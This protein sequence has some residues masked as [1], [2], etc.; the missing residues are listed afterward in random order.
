MRS[1]YYKALEEAVSKITDYYAYESA[2]N[3]LSELREETAMSAEGVNEDFMKEALSHLNIT[4]ESRIG[5]WKTWRSIMGKRNPCAK[6][7]E[8]MP[9]FILLK[10]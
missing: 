1:G 8:G 3:L 7:E 4:N 5:R 2:F 10:I 6:K 9:Q